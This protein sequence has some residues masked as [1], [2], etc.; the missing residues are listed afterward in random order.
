MGW[1]MGPEF[2]YCRH[3][4]H[5]FERILLIKPSA[6]GDVVHALP[7]LVK[8]RE[9]YPKARIDWMLTPHIAE[10]VGNHPAI[11]NVVLFQRQAYGKPWKNWT[12]TSSGFA[13]LIADLRDAHYDLVLDLH[14][15]FRSAF[16]A[17]VTGAQ[18][19][20][21][22]D[23]PR[24]SV[25]TAGRALPPQAFVHGWTGARE[26]SW[27]AYTHRIPIPTLDTHASQ[28]Y[29]WLG[30]IL[31]FPTDSPDF[32]VPVPEMAAAGAERI[33]A[34]R[35]LAQ[36]PLAV[37][38]PGTLW[39]TKHWP[40]EHFAEVANYLLK[41]GWA[42]ILAGSGKDRAVCQKVSAGAPGVLDV[43]GKTTLSELAA[44]IRRAG[45]CVTNDSGPMH[46]AAALGTPLVAIFGPTDS[47][48]VGP[49]G[50]PDA[51]V[52]AGL[53]C[54]PCYLRRIRDCPFGHACMRQVTPEQVIGRI[55]KVLSDQAPSHPAGSLQ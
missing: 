36:K 35:G 49:Y 33:L 52:R 38:S 23:R 25:R 27:M 2:S 10:L 18:T 46:L 29:L 48:W 51:V 40:A 44:L 39:E 14:G 19:R 30:D 37:L 13:K 20:I 34:E 54:S 42:V 50:Q 45:I 7:V 1:R 21:G 3:R 8:L 11:S 26:G 55:E 31:G 28:R 22:F 9:R 17:M 24:K 32:T 53:E 5:E 41:N 16:F 4:H 43:S 12:Q 47:L 15:Q 6:V